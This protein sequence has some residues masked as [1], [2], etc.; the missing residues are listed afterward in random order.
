MSQV[1]KV[2]FEII[3][4]MA[5]LTTRRQDDPRSIVVLVYLEVTNLDQTSSVGSPDVVPL[6]VLFAENADFQTVTAD[7][8]VAAGDGHLVVAEIAVQMQMDL[9]LVDGAVELRIE[10]HRCWT[11]VVLR[12]IVV[13]ALV[14]RIVVVRSDRH[15]CRR[16][17][18][19]RAVVITRT[20]ASGSTGEDLRFGFAER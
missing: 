12:W 3:E 14:I 18:R 19:P 5:T 7:R 20:Y 9:I 6:L 13:V 15:W 1:R 16:S 17:R 11:Y 2:Q 8:Q 4:T 10:D